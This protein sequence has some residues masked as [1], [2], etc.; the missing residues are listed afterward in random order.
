M[1]EK[2]DHKKYTSQ[3]FRVLDHKILK[4]VKKPIFWMTAIKNK[5]IVIDLR[6]TIPTYLPSIPSYQLQLID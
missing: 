4:L 3:Y 1:N 5:N 2:S 6:T